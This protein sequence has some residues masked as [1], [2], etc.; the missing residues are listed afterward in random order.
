MAENHA[1]TVVLVFAVAFVLAGAAQ[2][3]RAA[4]LRAR[5]RRATLTDLF[6]PWPAQ[7]QARS[8]S[9]FRA[10]VVCLVVAGAL[11]VLVT[12]SNTHY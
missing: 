1:A 2:L 3:V 6:E 9:A 4:V 7:V 11:G 10:G 8:R 12:M 5:S